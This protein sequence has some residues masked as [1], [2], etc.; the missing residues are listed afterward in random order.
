M[1]TAKERVWNE[2]MELVTKRDA[3]E[4]FMK[5]PAFDGMDDVQRGYLYTQNRIMEAYEMILRMRY[6]SWTE[7][8]G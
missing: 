3:L 6:N 4:R 5:T 8:R 7:I 1:S 2:I